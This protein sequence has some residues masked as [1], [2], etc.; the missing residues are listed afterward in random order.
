[1][2][3]RK[4]HPVKSMYNLREIF[5][6]IENKYNINVRDFDGKYKDFESFTTKKI[7]NFWSWFVEHYHVA[8][9][10]IVIIEIDR[11]L[12]DSDVPDWVKTIFRF[13]KDEKFDKKGKLESWIS[14]RIND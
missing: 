14:W 2:K 11:D 12:K 4:K 9:E 3:P 7:Q 6:Y 5:S 10:S 1:M 13:I 8:N